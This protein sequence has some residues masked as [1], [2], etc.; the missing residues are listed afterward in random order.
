MWQLSKQ[1]LSP[2]LALL[3][4]LPLEGVQ[5]Y[6]FHALDF[7]DNVLELSFW[8]LIVWFF[9]RAIN[10]V[11]VE[12]DTRA[13]F[14]WGLCSAV[15][16]MVKYYT[17]VL[18]IPLLLVTLY[19]QEYR[20]CWRTP[21]FYGAGV[22]ALGLM[23][24]HIVWL[25]QHDFITITYAIGR[26]NHASS[27]WW[28]HWYYPV[29][30]GIDQC[31]NAAPML[32]TLLPVVSIRRRTNAAKVMVAAYDYCFVCAVAL[33]PLLTTLLISM[34]T[35]GK[36]H[37]GWGQPLLSYWGL[38]LMLIWQPVLTVQQ[39]GRF[40][41]WLVSLTI[42]AVGIYAVAFVRGAEPSSANFPGQ[43]LANYV[44][45]TWQQRYHQP[46]GIV[47]GSRFL[48]TNVAFYSPDHPKTYLDANPAFSPWLNDKLIMIH[49]G[50]FVWFADNNAYHEL[51]RR[52][53]TISAPLTISLPYLRKP[54]LPPTVISVAY[55]PP[56]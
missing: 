24:P 28:H 23:M 2:A 47:A 18:I 43:Y 35:G 8:A 21:A 45:Q 36:L 9:Y 53:S 4:V 6:N 32:L 26:L 10:P 25:V 42:L 22:L 19:C 27:F 52:F 11:S 20:H 37:A 40:V 34:V 33:G 12:Q 55:V 17:I 7:N 49:G 15:G 3:A 51:Q 30:F 56:A 46:L 13:Y 14:L 54:E 50:A 39:I 29:Q 41:C 16:M 44:T 31:M 38:L 48:V 1:F 5:Y